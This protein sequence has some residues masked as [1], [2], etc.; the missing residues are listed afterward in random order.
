MLIH[1]HKAIC[2]YTFV[3]VISTLF[4]NPEMVYLLSG[5]KYG[6]PQRKVLPEN[7]MSVEIKTGLVFKLG[8]GL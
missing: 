7:L 1:C 3:M 8:L 6:F 4:Y 2:F 5:A